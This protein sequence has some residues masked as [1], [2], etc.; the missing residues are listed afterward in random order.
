MDKEEPIYNFE[1]FWL[2]YP[3]KV[4]K[5]KA[6]K[7]WDRMPFADKFHAYENLKLWNLAANWNTN[8]GMYIPYA[9]TF[10]AQRRWEDEPWVGA[11]EQTQKK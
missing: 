10:L 1:H 4:G 11:F 6:K 3:R 7:L 9:S 8:G 2:A 5:V